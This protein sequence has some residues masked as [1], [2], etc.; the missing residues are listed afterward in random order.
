MTTFN[1]TKELKVEIYLN[2]PSMTNGYTIWHI[3]GKD[4]K[5]AISRNADDKDFDWMTERQLSQFANGTYRFKM[6]ARMAIDMFNY[7]Y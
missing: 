7:M 6:T 2:C 1:Q 3:I 5:R 4:K